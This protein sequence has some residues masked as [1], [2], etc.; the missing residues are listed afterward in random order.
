MARP[1]PISWKALW[2]NRF[3]RERNAML[4]LKHQLLP[5][6]PA[7]PADFRLVSPT[8]VGQFHSLKSISLALSLSPKI[9]VS[10]FMYI[11]YLF[12]IS[13]EP[14]DTIGTKWSK[15]T[16]P[17]RAKRV[18]YASRCYVL[19]RTHHSGQSVTQSC[20]TRCDPMAEDCHLLFILLF[21]FKMWLISVTN[22]FGWAQVS[23]KPSQKAWCD[24]A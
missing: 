3:L 1:H 5:E 14:W 16:P 10:P 21:S 18:S 12:F 2:A 19:R 8:T 6:F 23:M 17:K 15:W 11:F 9:Y 4:R 20:P 24:R 7:Y 13:G 22:K